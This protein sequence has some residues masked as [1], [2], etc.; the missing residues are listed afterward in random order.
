MLNSIS[1]ILLGSAKQSSLAFRLALYD[2]QYNYG[3]YVVD[4]LSI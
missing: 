1:Y 3:S 2:V 4:S